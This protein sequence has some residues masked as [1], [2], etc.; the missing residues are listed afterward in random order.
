MAI[1]RKNSTD[2]GLCVSTRWLYKEW[3]S[4]IFS[5]SQEQMS[6]A[7]ESSWS[8]SAAWWHCLPGVGYLHR[9]FK[10]HNLGLCQVHPSCSERLLARTVPAGVNC[11]AVK[12]YRCILFWTIWLC[13]SSSLQELVGV[14]PAYLW[15]TFEL[16]VNSRWSWDLTVLSRMILNLPDMFSILQLKKNCVCVIFFLW[17]LY[18]LSAYYMSCCWQHVWENKTVQCNRERLEGDTH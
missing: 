14:H 13:S 2:T 16:K 1:D 12:G 11:E 8:C 6:L 15:A 3:D 9:L 4:A 7:L 18:L 17:I 10:E 5:P